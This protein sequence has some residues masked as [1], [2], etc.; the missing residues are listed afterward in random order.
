MKNVQ[1]Y[2][3]VFASRLCA[4]QVPQKCPPAHGGKL[5]AFPR[6][7]IH[8]SIWAGAP[9]LGDDAGHCTPGLSVRNSRGATAEDL[10]IYRKWID[11]MVV[12]YGALLLMSGVV[13]VLIV[14]GLGPTRS[15][16]LA[17]RS[18]AVAHQTK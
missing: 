17:A 18:T 5:I 11:G 3:E 4:D 9:E 13:A 12:F 6:R 8:R 14:A 16:S 15:P 7:T 2:A 1:D 10:A